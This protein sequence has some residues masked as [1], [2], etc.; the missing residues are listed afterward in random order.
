[1]SN[2]RLVILLSAAVIMALVTVILYS[3]RDVPRSEFRKGSYLIQG[4]DPQRVGS[5]VIKK[6]SDTV[7][8]A[9]DGDEFVVSERRNY[10]ALLKK[11]NS[12]IVDVL[13]TRCADKVTDDPE[14]HA[15]LGVDEGGEDGI[16]LTFLDADGKALIGLVRGKSSE[17][18]SGV[19]ARLL[20]DDAVYRTDGYF[21]INASPTDFMERTLIKVSRDDIKQVVVSAGK[22]S[23]TIAR[24]D[25][26]DIALQG[27]PK[28][29]QAK[30]TEVEDV[31]TELVSLELTDVS[32]AD[33]LDLTWDAKYSCEL[34]SGLVY[35]VQLAQDGD[36]NY[37]KLSAKGPGVTSVQITRTEAEEELKKKESILLAAETAKKFT[38]QHAAWVY[39]ISSRSAEKMRKKLDELVE[40]I[41]TAEVPDEIAASHI[42]IA[43]KGAERSDATRTKDEA[44]KLADEVRGKAMSEGADFAALAEEYSDGPSKTKGGDLG[45]FKKGKMAPA[46]EEAAFALDVDAISD[47]VETP[48]GFHIIKRTK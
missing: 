8:L 39:E 10:P 36:K 25:E 16:T 37:V 48:F 24:N 38:P 19:Y 46:F 40:D 5:I 34:K 14:N 45:A 13:K 3:G 15:G 9:R 22:Q 41:P 21:Y 43:Y 32:P 26:D 6:G 12:L 20:G 11:I 44:R 4:L 31:F 1:M 23:Y 42:L 29:K 47:V 35:H 18:G 30:Q 33:A 7:T 28:G 2:R 27:I 17:G